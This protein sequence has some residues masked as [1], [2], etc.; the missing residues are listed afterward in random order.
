MPISYRIIKALKAVYVSTCWVAI[1]RVIIRP[2]T[3]QHENHGFSPCLPALTSPEHLNYVRVNPSF[4]VQALPF[5]QDVLTAERALLY[6]LGFDLNVRQ[7]Y[8]VTLEITDKFHFKENI[9][10]P[11]LLRDILQVGETSKCFE[12]SLIPEHA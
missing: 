3:G 10:D 7:P 5:P 9:Q 6:V 11:T 4:N 2:C 12:R 1:F 8:G